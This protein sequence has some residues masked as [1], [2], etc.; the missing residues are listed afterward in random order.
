VEDLYSVS[1]FPNPTSGPL[2]ISISKPLTKTAT[3]NIVDAC[4]R[5]CSEKILQ[6]GIT[7]I[8]MNISDLARGIYLLR[9]SSTEKSFSK[10]IIRL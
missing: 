7:D 6:A 4:G 10:K 3:V 2:H 8:E 1:V 5:V 9:I